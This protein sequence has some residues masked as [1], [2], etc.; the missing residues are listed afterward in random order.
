MNFYRKC[1]DNLKDTDYLLKR[2]ISLEVQQ[3]FWIGYC[4][5]W[6]SPTALRKGYNPPKTPRII[7]P[8]STNS[9]I[10]VDVPPRENITEEE[11]TTFRFRAERNALNDGF[12]RAE[13]HFVKDFTELEAL[14]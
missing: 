6:Q 3:K 10:A 13:V 9:Y 14:I 2:G 4:A 8:T 5:K 11:K 1:A 7:I 12:E